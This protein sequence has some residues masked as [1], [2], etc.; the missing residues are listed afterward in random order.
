MKKVLLLAALLVGLGVVAKR[1]CPMTGNVDW[2]KRFERMPESSPPKWMFRN[3][4][5]I[6]DNTDRILALVEE[7]RTR[8]ATPPAATG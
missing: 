6:R 2:Q 7:D 1:L 5:A 8:S 4:S 3:I